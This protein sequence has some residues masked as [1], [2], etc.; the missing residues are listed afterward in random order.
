M[1]CPSRQEADRAVNACYN[2]KTLPGVSGTM[3]SIS[4]FILFLLFLL[5]FIKNVAQYDCNPLQI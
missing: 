4:G 3:I 2:K 1:I 5:I